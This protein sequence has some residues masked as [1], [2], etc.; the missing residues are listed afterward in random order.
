[1]EHKT[2]FLALAFVLIF[3][4][5]VSAQSYVFPQSQDIDLK[6]TCLDENNSYCNN[7]TL[8]NLT[9][10]DPNSIDLI[11]NEPT[12]HNP[13]FYNYTLNT[14]QTETTGVYEAKV[15]CSGTT[16]GWSAFLYEVTPTGTKLSTPQSII[17][18]VLLGFLILLLVLDMF[19]IGFVGAKSK[20]ATT[21]EELLSVSSL[22][23]VK[24]VLYVTGYALLWG[25]IFIASNISLAYLNFEMLGTFLFTLSK[26]MLIL[27]FPIFII[28]FIWIFVKIFQDKEMKSMIERGVDMGRSP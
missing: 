5:G 14:T 7:A 17:Y 10:T 3:T 8:C 28:W 21:N 22:K 20:G 27:I 11:T 2:I 23:Y 25:I 6:I 19:G 15:F 26:I 18:F 16:D 12:T 4:A 9:I 24:S 1:M 13:T